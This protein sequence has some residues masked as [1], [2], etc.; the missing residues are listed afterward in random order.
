MKN[1]FKAS[2]YFATAVIIGGCTSFNKDN[3]KPETKEP[4]SAKEVK[5]LYLPIGGFT[6]GFIY[7]G[8]DGEKGILDEMIREGWEI[9]SITTQNFQ[10]SKRNGDV[11]SCNG[12]SYLLER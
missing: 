5:S 3:L 8:F 7:C 4:K 12:S 2:I 10:T 11:V 6:S 9:K 1:F